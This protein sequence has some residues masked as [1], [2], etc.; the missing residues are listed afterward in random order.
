[1]ATS[2]RNEFR[3]ALSHLQCVALCAAVAGLHASGAMMALFL[4]MQRTGANTPSFQAS[5]DLA[6]VFLWPSAI[7]MLGAQS[8]QGGVVLFGMSAC[9]NAAYFV[10]VSM[11][12]LAVVDKVRSHSRVPARVSV[13]RTDSAIADAVRV[14][15]TAA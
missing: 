2:D 1:M 11:F 3:K 6:C 15:R 4:W 10:F 7:L 8:V 9:L 14:P 12:V 13:R 5:F